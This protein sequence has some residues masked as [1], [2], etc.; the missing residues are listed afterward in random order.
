[1]PEPTVD[2]IK[3]LR[4]KAG[5]TQRQAAE[6]CAVSKRAWQSWELRNSGNQMPA[7][8]WKLFRIM[9]AVREI[10]KEDSSD[11]EGKGDRE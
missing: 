7:G 1:M 10:E 4:I 2:E 3:K 5:L 6:M 9:V 8:M 11:S